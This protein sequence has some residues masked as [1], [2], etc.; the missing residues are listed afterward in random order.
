MLLK[1]G[2][3][4][5]KIKTRSTAATQSSKIRMRSFA[6]A[7]V[8]DSPEAIVVGCKIKSGAAAPHSKRYKRKAAVAFRPPL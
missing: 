3:A 5:E 4:A 6:T 8:F 7:N 2:N 1:N